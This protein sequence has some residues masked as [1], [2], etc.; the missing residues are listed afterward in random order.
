M[1]HSLPILLY[2]RIDRSGL[3]TATAP[4]DFRRHLQWLKENGWR[5][6]DGA[7]LTHLLRSGKALPKRAFVITFDDGYESLASAAFPILQEFRYSAICFLSTQFIPG[8]R[9]W[10]RPR[11]AQVDDAAFLT[12]DQVR[13]LQSCGVID[14]HSHTHTHRRFEECTMEELTE[15]LAMPRRILAGELGLPERHFDHLAWPWGRSTPEW[16]ALAH[17]LGYRYQY[18]VARQSFERHGPLDDIPRTCFDAAAFPQFQRQI[19][20]Q[21]G[22]IG[23]MWNF[24]YPFGRRLRQITGF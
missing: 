15:D 6:L 10:K 2:H 4:D 16:R 3:S 21:S 5:A 7:Q 11:E 9:S 1:A 8:A 24:A 17:R 14:F 23:R 22:S 20:L 12:W 19:W 13:A 18:T